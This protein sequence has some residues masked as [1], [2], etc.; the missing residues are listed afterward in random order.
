MES[1]H[2][3]GVADVD[4]LSLSTGFVDGEFRLIMSFRFNPE[5]T[6]RV[7]NVAITGHQAVRLYKD[8]NHIAGCYDSMKQEIANY[9]NAFGSYEA[10]ILD[11]KP[12]VTKKKKKNKQ[13]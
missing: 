7:T 1:S 5:Q 12:V 10:V 13:D 11:E 8:L 9:S 4:L 3:T 6:A 2:S